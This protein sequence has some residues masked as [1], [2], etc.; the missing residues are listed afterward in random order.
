LR[1]DRCAPS[2][3]AFGQK[4]DA[5]EFARAHGGEVLPFGEVAAAFAK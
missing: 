5:A 3:I 1:Y 4:S 2:L